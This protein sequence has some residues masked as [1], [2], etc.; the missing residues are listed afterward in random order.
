[1]SPLFLL[2]ILV[3]LLAGLLGM[4][5]MS[6]RRAVPTRREA[7]D[8]PKEVA[9][10]APDD[11]ESQEPVESEDPGD[12]FEA[13]DWESE[14]DSRAW[15]ELAEAYEAVGRYDEAARALRAAVESLEEDQA[16]RAYELHQELAALYIRRQSPHE[17]YKHLS[18][19]C[20][21]AVLCF[22]SPSAQQ[23]EA[24]NIIGEFLEEQGSWAKA[25][26]KYHEA[27]E[28]EQALY[29]ASAEKIAAAQAN[30]GRMC[31]RL[32]DWPEALDH[33]LA[34]HRIVAEETSLEDVRRAYLADGRDADEFEGWLNR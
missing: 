15:Q 28:A 26:A 1:M 2:L 14:R 16:D 5:W 34:A 32:A 22:G 33:Y 12:L 30:L 10:L 27:L 21:C 31:E 18:D 23:V 7:A 4:W 9:G 8:S 29:G 25:Y 19:A 24:L 20:A 6:K 17:A 3:L 11:S 13:V